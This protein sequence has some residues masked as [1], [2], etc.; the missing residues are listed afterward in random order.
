MP[1]GERHRLT[2]TL[3][4]A[5]AGW[6]GTLAL[7]FTVVLLAVSPGRA[8]AANPS[9][10]FDTTPAADTNQTSATFAFHAA[11]GGGSALTE[12]S[13]DSAAFTSCTSPAQLSGLAEGQHS[14]SAR[15]VGAAPGSSATYT[16]TVDLT[17]PTTEVTAQPPSLT[18]ST[19]A[20][21]AFTS[22][23]PTAGF[24]CSL[25]GSPPQPCTSPVVY[26]GLADA[27]RSL[28][29]QAVDR[30][31]NVDPLAQ[32]INWTVDTTPPDTTLA[33]P[34]NLIGQPVA[35]FQ[36]TST[37]AGA[38]FQCSFGAA[39]FAACTSPYA[40]DVPGSGAQV[41]KV[42]AV[43]PAGNVDPTPAVYRWTSD[44]TP[45]RRPKVT[46]FPAPSA[47]A[48]RAAPVP[49]LQKAQQPGLTFTNPLA[50]LLRTPTFTLALRLHAQWSSDATATSFDVTVD[51]V[52]Q[53]STG[54]GF[55]GED[56]L[57]YREYSHTK[58]TALTLKLYAGTTV[59][60][61]VSARDKAGN[62]SRPR[63]ACTTIPISFTPRDVGPPPVRDAK[64]WRGYYIRLGGGGY[65]FTQDIGD[66]FYFSPRHAALVAERCPHC[67]TVEFDFMHYGQ[68][69]R[70]HVLATVDLDAADH[71][72]DFDLITVPLP[73]RRLE[74]DG[75]GL[76]VIR[77]A[78]GRPRIAGIA[79]SS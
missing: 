70:L 61:K 52:P 41:F 12:C 4:H 48:S 44:L 1:G 32:P 53:D 64:A 59:C 29:I 63:T 74:S 42:R 7:L 14:F 62:T 57:S 6:A 46:I 45:P 17:P 22:P 10:I 5:P 69:A 34:G 37:E 77:A 16:W 11:S 78:A 18:N 8:A 31:G 39:A 51:S 50:T 72:G 19:T 38:T 13:L 21:F 75:E 25:N 36:F 49:T 68:H 71:S 73:V 54:M 66:E 56:V 23:D 28:L 76:L 24:R 67:G 35:V 65:Q 2:V 60:V 58:R 30:A 20:T 26:T 27:S 43:D 9:V 33:N 55:H 3:T 79:L 15:T 47:S 40:V